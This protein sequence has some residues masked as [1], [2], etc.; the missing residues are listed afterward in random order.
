MRSKQK[1]VGLPF[2]RVSVLLA[3]VGALAIPSPTMAAATDP[4]LAAAG[5]GKNPAVTDLNN[6][7]GQSSSNTR[8]IHRIVFERGSDIYTM[9]PNGSDVQDVT[10][11]F[12]SSG[13]TFTDQDPVWSWDGQS[14]A[15]VCNR[16][17]GGVPVL[18]VYTMNADGTGLERVTTG[19]ND[20]MPV[21]SPGG[22]QLAFVGVREGL[23]VGIYVIGANGAGER[24][25]VSGNT[26]FPDWSP[27]GKKILFDG[28]ANPNL[29]AIVNGPSSNCSLY[30]IQPD[31]LNKTLLTHDCPGF[32]K[33]S[34]DGTKIAFLRH[35]QLWVMNADG[36]GQTQLTTG[37]L[38]YK[39]SWSP[40]GS[41]FVISYL[42]PSTSGAPN[43]YL[44]NADGTGLTQVTSSPCSPQACG[45]YTPSWQP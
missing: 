43:L 2:G 37:G 27:D 17:S 23:P 11:T 31:G 6:T 44:I 38:V 35:G 40:D 22:K 25:L 20:Y 19:E 42:P 28:S 33:W 21:W 39:E 45:D 10:N 9:K 24:L 18:D 32:P 41:Q 8:R 4:L 12:A 34:P 30:T 14:I 7:V 15:F 29:D 36:S 26:W 16:G 1:W 13:F 3:V 5:C